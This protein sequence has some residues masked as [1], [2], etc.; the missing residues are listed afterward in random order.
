MRDHHLRYLDKLQCAAGRVIEEELHKIAAKEV[1]GNPDG[2]FDSVNIRC[3]DFQYKDTR[4]EAH[5]LVKKSAD[6][7]HKGALLYVILQYCY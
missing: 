6:V 1:E 2:L 3:G 5:Q 4:L 7:P